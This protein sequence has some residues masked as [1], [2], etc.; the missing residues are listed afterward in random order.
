MP[1]TSAHPQEFKQCRSLGHEWKHFGAELHGDRICQRSRCTDCKTTREKWISRAGFLLGTRYLY[2]D[3]YSLHGEDRLPNHEWR[4]LY[5]ETLFAP[6]GPN[7][8]GGRKK[9]AA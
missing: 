2:P 9:V 6:T 4:S 1:T 8:K 7:D 3:G 5:V